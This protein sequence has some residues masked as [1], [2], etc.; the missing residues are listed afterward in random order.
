MDLNGPL[1]DADIVGNLLA[2]AAARDLDRI[3]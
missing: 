1:G 3:S 2:E